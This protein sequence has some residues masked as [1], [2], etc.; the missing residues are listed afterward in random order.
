M[1]DYSSAA[2]ELSSLRDFLRWTTSKFSEAGLFYGHGNEDAFN[3][4]MQLILHSLYLPVTEFPELFID[5]RLTTQEKQQIV[6]LVKKRIEKRIPV[7]YLTK[8][9]WFAQLPFFVDERVLIP[10]SPFAELIAEEFS[11]WLI[12]P[13]S[14]TNIL[15]LCTG[16]ACIAIACAYAFP[17]ASVDAIDI[18][19]DAIDVANINIEKHNIGDRVTAIQSNLWQQC[20]DKHY[21]IIV[22]NPPYVGMAEMQ[23]LPA[24]YKHEPE[25]ALKAEDNGLAIVEQILLK[26]AE[27]LSPDGILIVEVGNSDEAVVEKWPETPFTWLEF[28]Q[29]G[30]GL[31]ML[32]ATQCQQFS[33]RYN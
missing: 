7:P 19:S 12:E 20:P 3:E 28:E 14:V 15:D 1:I 13:D 30:H 23:T 21:D 16:S 9:A 29:G 22:S 18:S 24:E 26:A 27:F 31:F 6:E 2:K 17:D 32:D 11:P 5:C 10:R 4:A 8:E 33:E 25:L